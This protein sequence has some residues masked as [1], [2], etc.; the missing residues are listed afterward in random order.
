ME[1]L[2]AV[3]CTRQL[4]VFGDISKLLQNAGGLQ[5]KALI[6]KQFITPEDHCRG[7]QIKPQG[8]EHGRV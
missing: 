1:V 2:R 7:G 3:E 8:L 5:A 6:A 4:K